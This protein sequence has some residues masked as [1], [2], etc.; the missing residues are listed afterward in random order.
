MS[1]TQDHEEQQEEMPNIPEDVA[2]AVHEFLIHLPAHIV[3]RPENA[4]PFH[5]NITPNPAPSML[6]SGHVPTPVVNSRCF[7]APPRSPTS[8]PPDSPPRQ[9]TTSLGGWSRETGEGYGVHQGCTIINNRPDLSGPAPQS[10]SSSRNNENPP[11]SSK[12]KPKA[13]PKKE[14]KPAAA[15]S[16]PAPAKYPALVRNNRPK[17]ARNSPSK[18]SNNAANASTIPLRGTDFPDTGFRPTGTLLTKGSLKGRF[19]KDVCRGPPP[20]G[21]SSTEWKKKFRSA[22]SVLMKQLQNKAKLD[23]MRDQG[24]VR[25]RALHML[26]LE[27]QKRAAAAKAE[28]KGKK[29]KKA[30]VKEEDVEMEDADETEESEEEDEE[31]EDA[32]DEAEDED[33]DG[34]DG[35]GGAGNDGPGTGGP[36]AAGPGA[37]GPPPGG[38]GAGGAGPG[39]TGVV[40]PTDPHDLYGPD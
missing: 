32:E 39:P 33:G 20:A 14:S 37:A 25:D 4:D 36:G 6:D 34:Q 23:T 38:Y 22:E 16:K 27:W 9:S 35:N 1:D 19:S 21:C 7:V 13:A 26:S 40:N 2:R 28:K 29:G 17:A 18:S 8:S 30:A 11:E 3:P 24:W 5:G 12:P 15:K 31:M 10:S